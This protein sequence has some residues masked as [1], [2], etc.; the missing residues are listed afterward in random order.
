MSKQGLNIT[1]ADNAL[2]QQP[3]GQGTT[4]AV[5]GCSSGTTVPNF[6]PYTTTNPA[7]ISGNSG[8]G[9][10][11]RLA[12]FIT[13]QSGNP[14]ECV[15]VPAASPGVVTQVYTGASNTSAT[16]MTIS[17]T[18]NDDYY[19]VVTPQTSGTMGTAGVVLGISLDGGATNAYTVN[20]NTATTVTTGSAFTTYTGLSLSFTVAAIVKND[21]F[22]AVGTAPTFSDAAIQSAITALAAVKGQQFQD[23]IVAGVSGA[24]DVSAFDGYMTTLANTNR[25]FARLLCSA[26]DAVWGGASTETEAAWLASIESAFS[27]SSSLRVGVAAGYYRFIDPFTQSQM[28]SSLLYGAAGRDSSVGPAIDLGEVDN[29]ALAQVVL[30]TGPDNFA[31]GTFIYHDEDQ[32]PG[33]DAARFLSSWQLVGF[34]GIYIMNSNLMA[35][36]GSDFNWLQH[37]HVI[38]EACAITYQYFTLT[39]SRPVRVSAKTGFILAQDRAKLQ[40]GCNAALNNALVGQVSSVFCIVSGT[41]NILSTSTL[42]VTVYVVPLG[43]IKSVNATVTFLNPAIV[44]VNQAA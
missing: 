40:N 43:Y 1:I 2:G 3:P 7:T 10:M 20:M 25:R 34:P 30:P 42:T 24:A 9:P 27:N 4:L 11:P 17:G 8:F 5:I 12:A 16:V 32:N 19:L 26:R 14:V 33:L 31:K 6:V 38:D 22:Y 28:R 15:S 13:T 21:T 37:G 39:L 35:P 41:D 44:A 36:P 29:G 18:P 23:I